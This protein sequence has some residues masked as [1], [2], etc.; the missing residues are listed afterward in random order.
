MDAHEAKETTDTINTKYHMILFMISPLSRVDPVQ[1]RM[2][3]PRR[4]SPRHKNRAARLVK[5][6][7]MAYG[8]PINTGPI[9]SAAPGCT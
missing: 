6:R 8:K 1:D 4:H 3:G 7:A 2:P 9:T 5:A